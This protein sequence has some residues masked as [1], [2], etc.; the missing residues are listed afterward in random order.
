MKPA[1]LILGASDKP[2]RFSNRA[3]HKLQSHGFTPIL[4][5]PKGGL[6][7]GIKCYQSLAEVIEQVGEKID[8]ITVYINASLISDEIQNI[9]KLN[10]RRVIFNPGTE[11]PEAASSLEK[12]RIE[13]VNKCTLVML[14]IGIY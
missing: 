10:P 1:T 2:E 12:E 7:D 13:V 14:D 4:V 9:L 11:S 3:L 6:I 8:T 5:S